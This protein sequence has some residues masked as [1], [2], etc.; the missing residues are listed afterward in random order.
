MGFNKKTL[1]GENVYMAKK[2]YIT[3][4]N[5]IDTIKSFNFT[6]NFDKSID[7]NQTSGLSVP[8]N[9]TPFNI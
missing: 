4:Q 7:G 6:S 5:I 3:E 1:D 8:L 9:Q 2:P